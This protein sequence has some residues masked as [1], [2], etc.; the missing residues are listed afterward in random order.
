MVKTP[1]PGEASAGSGEAL[2]VAYDAYHL[3][4]SAMEELERGMVTDLLPF[5]DALPAG[6][7]GVVAL[8]VQPNHPYAD[9]GRTIEQQKF[10]E[11]GED[12]DFHEGMAAYEANS[13][14]VYTVDLK[15]GKQRIAHCKRVVF[16][17]QQDQ[18]DAGEPTR[19]EP[20]DDRVSSPVEEEACGLDEVLAYH[21]I[22]DISRCLNVA[23]NATT[24]RLEGGLEDPYTLISYKA[25]F[26]LVATNG[27]QFVTAYL[28]K[29]AERSLDTIQVVNQRVLGREFHLPLGD[30]E[31]DEAYKAVVIPADAHNVDVFCKPN[32]ENEFAMFIAP[33]PVPLFAADEAGRNLIE[34]PVPEAA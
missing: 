27:I 8:A 25:I 15:D 19:I 28:N 9:F 23:T 24:D 10:T 16:A 29:Y 5:R 31:Y 18:L 20:F 14:F 32:P 11:R 2:V 33:R 12:Y 30:G 26:E 4:D 13:M 1:T 21:G 6:A 17:N 7:N 3:D 34:V 22:S